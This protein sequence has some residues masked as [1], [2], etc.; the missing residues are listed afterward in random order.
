M[1]SNQLLVRLWEKLDFV[2]A[3]KIPNA[4]R[5]KRK[6][7][8]GEEYVDAWVF[9]KSFESAESAESLVNE[10]TVVHRSFS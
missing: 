9:Y 2:K 8:Q 7:G 4:G 5:L 1:I 6:D 3:G 10:N